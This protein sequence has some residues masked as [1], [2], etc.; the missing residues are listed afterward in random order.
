M[1]IALAQMN[2]TVGDLDSNCRHILEL[3]RDVSGQK[4]DLLVVPELAVC[5]YPPK[6]LLLRS[7]FVEVKT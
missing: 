4:A 6:D 1:R 7:G 2:L 3:A 5:G